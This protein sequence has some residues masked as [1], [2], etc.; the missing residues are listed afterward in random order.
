M[1]IL[2]RIESWWWSV[3][4]P[5][6]DEPERDDTTPVVIAGWIARHKHPAT[7][8]GGDPCNCVVEG[9]G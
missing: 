3:S 4:H 5:E 6:W 8:D 9:G 1:S 2:R 7:C